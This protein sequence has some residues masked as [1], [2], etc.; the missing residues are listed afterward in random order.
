MLW[1]ILAVPPLV[2]ELA[3]FALGVFMPTE[4]LTVFIDAQNVYN[5]ARRAFYSASDSHVCGQFMPLALAE[6]ICSQPPSGVT[7]ILNQVRIYSGRPDATKDPKTHSAHMKQCSV[8]AKAGVK[9]ITRP[10]RYPPNWPSEH[11]QEKGIDVTLAIDFVSFAVDC[12]HDVGVIASFDTDLIPALEFVS[13]RYHNSCRI[14][15]IGFDS[16][17]TPKKRL[18]LKGRPNLWCYWINRALFDTIAD[19]T[20][21]NLWVCVIVL[22]RQ[23]PLLSKSDSQF[24]PP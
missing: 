8:W 16:T 6:W 1:I 4:R 3:R 23:Y 11:A 15:V 22:T 17:R 19:P 13:D 12:L 2:G 5:A 18:R 10:L 21:Y 20:D 9:V 7:R 14:E 24:P